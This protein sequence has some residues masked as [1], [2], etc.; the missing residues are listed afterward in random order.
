MDDQVVQD[1]AK[2]CDAFKEMRNGM[3]DSPKYSAKL[4]AADV[5]YHAIR[6]FAP[7]IGCIP[8]YLP[9]GDDPYGSL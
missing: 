7:E 6:Q 8:P 1:F 9:I 2:I 3:L 4:A 5:L